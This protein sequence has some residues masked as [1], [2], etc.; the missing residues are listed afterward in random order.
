MPPIPKEGNWQLLLHS[1]KVEYEHQ[2]IVH[3]AN[4]MDSNA[5]TCCLGANFVILSHSNR[6]ADVYAYDTS[7]EP[8][9][10]V[11][12]V[13]GVTTYLDPVTGRSYLL[14]INEGL[15]YG[16]KLDH[17]LINPNQVL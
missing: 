3:A 8:T 13:T 7:L 16:T 2:S 5:D 11:P 4:K 10:N 9:H 1:F 17:S 15:Y 14:I 6:F 12:I